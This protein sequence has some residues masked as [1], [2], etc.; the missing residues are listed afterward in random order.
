VDYSDWL[1]VLGSFGGAGAEAYFVHVAINCLLSFRTNVD[2]EIENA[3]KL[4]QFIYNLYLFVIYL[5]PRFL[6]YFIY[7]YLS[8]LF[9]HLFIMYFLYSNR[10]VAIFVS[11]AILR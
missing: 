1:V 6:F 4:I 9:R 3:S 8:I 10:F 11:F 5:Y 7:F 2:E